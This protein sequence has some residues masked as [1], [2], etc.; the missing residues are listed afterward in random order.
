MNPL[1]V[2]IE[3]LTT[4]L[5]KSAR[6]TEKVGESIADMLVPGDVV[7]LTGD[8]G[9]G[10]TTLIK[11]LVQKTTGVPST[12][13]VSPTFTY[14]NIYSGLTNIYHF[15]LYRFSSGEEFL[16]AGFHEFLHRKGICCIE[17][18]DRLPENLKIKK[19]FIHIEYLSIEER[20]ITLRRSNES[21]IS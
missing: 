2:Q 4:F 17:W 13:V 3:I 11:G 14:L 9:A 5:T 1:P 21:I 16:L 18:P 19:I 10:K 20:Q 7:C 15:D 8:L 12:E 6:D